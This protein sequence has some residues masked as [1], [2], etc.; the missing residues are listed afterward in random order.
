MAH[1]IELPD[2][3]YQELE[4]IAQR[5]Q[6]SIEELLVEAVQ[7]YVTYQYEDDDETIRK[8]FLEG[9]HQVMTNAPTRS[10]WDVLDEIENDP[11][12]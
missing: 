1:L 2:R 9:W 3:L 12:A 8:E 10:I 11:Q 4:T 5:N 6:R 7:G